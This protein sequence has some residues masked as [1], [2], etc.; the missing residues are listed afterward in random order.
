MADAKELDTVSSMWLAG[1]EA[2]YRDALVEIWNLEHEAY[3]ARDEERGKL[4]REVATEVRTR[5][6]RVLE[7]TATRV[8]RPE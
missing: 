3:E 6:D 1:H 5:M 2:G 4:L 8:V 7:Q